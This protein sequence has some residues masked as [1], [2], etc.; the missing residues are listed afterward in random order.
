MTYNRILPL[1]TLATIVLSYVLHGQTYPPSVLIVT[2]HPDDEM[3][4][5]A[6]VYKITH[7]LK[8]RVDLAVITNG[9][10]GFKYSTLAEAYYGAELTDERVGRSLLPTIRKRELM[11][12]GNIIGIRS[13]YFLDQQDNAYTL[14]VDSVL[15]YVWDVP[16]IKNTLRSLLDRGAYDII[17][18][19]LPTTDTHGHHKG[20][21]ILALDVVMGLPAERRPVILGGTTSSS[22][23]TMPI[24]YTGLGQYP[25]TS[26]SSGR[27]SFRFDRST[28]FGFRDRLDYRIIVKWLI[29]EH[30]S[31][32]AI[33]MSSNLADFED[34][35]WFDIN[36]P[37][38]LDSV[39]TLF[40]RLAVVPYIKRTY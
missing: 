16:L 25:A 10:A 4:F 1:A 17:F 31:Q 8:G 23:D 24:Q 14:N 36:D 28:K 5:A 3:S 11:S 34:F 32:G 33:H 29:A 19:L 35:W 9:E 13:Y 6:T 15:R 39:R 30:K 2:A 18:V 26:V 38:R 7:D 20:A 22:L 27:S 40:E 12:G 37:S 21:A